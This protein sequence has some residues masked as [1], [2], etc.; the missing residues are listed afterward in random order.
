MLLKRLSNNSTE[1]TVNDGKILFSYETPVAVFVKNIGYYRTIKN[2]S[3]TTS[4]HINLWLRDIE[5]YKATQE[6]LE[7]IVKG[8][9]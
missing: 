4:K 1:L 2:H 9:K 3:R 5:A 8:I 7:T 6:T